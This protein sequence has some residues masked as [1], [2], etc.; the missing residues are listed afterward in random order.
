MAQ[1]GECSVCNYEREHN[2]QVD[3][4]TSKTEWEARTGISR[5]AIRR[6]LAHPARDV[7]AGEAPPAGESETH[8]PKAGSA[9]TIA[10]DRPWG[11]SDFRKFIRSKG[12]DP[13]EVT[14]TWGWTSNP[15]GGFWNKINGVRPK[16]G[17][18]PT[19]AVDWG[20]AAKFVE[21]FTYVPSRREFLTDVAVLQPTDEQLGKVDVNGGTPETEERVM[22]S[23]AAFADYLQEFRPRRAVLAHTGDGI[24]NFCNTSSQRDT[25][26]LDLPSMLV[27]LFRLDLAAIRILAPLTGEIL[28][29]YAPSNHGRWR[30]GLKSE[31]GNPHADFG[32][33]V[34]RQVEI[35]LEQTGFAPN[36]KTL[37]PGKEMESMTV[38]AGA[39]RIGMVHGHQV[40][41]PD[42]LG[43]WWAKQDH[44]RMPTWDADVLL[45]G[46]FHSFRSQQSGDKRWIFVGPSS[47]NGSSWYSNLK[48][49]TASA[50]MLALAFEGKQWRDLAI[51]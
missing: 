3:T 32:I 16:D 22:N 10:S 44:G 30:T 33:A 4:S 49:E 25:N 29:A 21:G 26:D 45:A 14:F 12:Q 50:G 2:V 18:D 8:D 11:E 7:G 36:V 40:N 24:E 20:R 19:K 42:K 34:G 6:H 23:Y 35:A 47:D 31:A 46:H 13:D 1:S 51:L 28:N 37:F 15:A 41:S 38:D 5:H 43:D 27:H 39:V 48:G 17:G 9:Y